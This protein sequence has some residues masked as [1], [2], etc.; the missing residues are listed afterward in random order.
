MGNDPL[1]SCRPSVVFSDKCFRALLLVKGP[2][3]ASVC[4]NG[5]CHKN[6]CHSQ[7]TYED[8]EIIL[9]HVVTSSLPYLFFD[10]LYARGVIN[11]ACTR[12]ENRM[13]FDHTTGRKQDDA[14]NP[15]SSTKPPIRSCFLCFSDLTGFCGKS[16]GA[17]RYAV[18]YEKGAMI[19]N[20]YM[21]SILMKSDA[22][23][24]PKTIAE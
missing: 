22:A 18:R 5:R 24:T 10:I 1:V 4:R 2:E 15:V 19:T 11:E 17:Y 7:Q 23:T 13:I 14:N 16:A 6:S 9:F 21:R 3:P 20:K 12:H 8:L